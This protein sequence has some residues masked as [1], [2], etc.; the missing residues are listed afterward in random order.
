M[1][2]RSK[3]HSRIRVAL[4]V[5]LASSVILTFAVGTFGQTIDTDATYT[6]IRKAECKSLDP[7][8]A[9]DN[10]SLV[11]L[12]DIFQRLVQVDSEDATNLIG[13]AAASWSLSEDGLSYTFHIREGLKFH[14]G[15][16]LTAHDVKFSFDRTVLM[17]GTA[18]LAAKLNLILGAQAYIDSGMTQADADAYLAAG[19]VVVEDDYTV[20]IHLTQINIP[21]IKVLSLYSF[22]G[23]EDY[24]MAN[25]GVVPGE[26]NDWI[27]R[28]PMGSGSFT[29]VEWV[30]GQ[31]VVLER[32]EEY[33]EGPANVKRVVAEFISE[34]SVQ[35][36]KLRSGEADIIELAFSDANQV[37]DL[38]TG[39]ILFPEIQVLS[40]S[41]LRLSAVFFNHAVSPYDDVRFREAISKA[42][43]CDLF[44]EAVLYDMFGNRING[45][46]PMGMSAYPSDIPLL[47]NDSAEAKALFE[48]IG[49]TG[50]LDMTIRSNNATSKQL[51]LMMKDSIEDL[52]VGI[53]VNIEELD[54]STFVGQMRAGELDFWNNSWGASA[55]DAD[56]M[57]EGLLYSTGYYAN[58][59]SF[60]SEEIDAL[61][62]AARAELNE[63]A[64]NAMYQDIIEKGN[65]LYVNIPLYQ[66]HALAVMGSWMGGWKSSPLLW[67]RRSYFIEKYEQ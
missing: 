32:Y 42:F 40:Y 49:W 67:D 25:G 53:T 60:V 20:A 44:I 37:L 4:L 39:E 61:F 19:G 18:G 24:V 8:N 41:L 46:I 58:Q 23:S 1:R 64:R 56:P 21:F 63:E 17:N 66:D 15:S 5:F 54:S 16:D 45:I 9:R 31:R 2:Y 34:A 65:A 27:A 12:A 59:Q 26:E 50:T 47:E 57:V 36:L 55:N 28:N 10:Y 3:R 33:W 13:D 38:E 6:Y 11:I 14:D 48:E 29:F 30:P 35:L 52:D 62:L 43:P 51:A 7:H 22:I